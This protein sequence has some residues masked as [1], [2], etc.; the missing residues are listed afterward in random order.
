[1]SIT[2]TNNPYPTEPDASPTKLDR[3]GYEGNAETLDEK[4]NTNFEEVKELITSK[5]IGA[6][7]INGVTP[8]SAI[9]VTGNIYTVV[10]AVGTYVNWNNLVVSANNLAIL[11]R[12]NGVFSISQT[13][14]DITNLKVQNWTAKAYLSGDQVNYLGKDWI[15][16]AATLSTDIPNAS[17]KWSERLGGYKSVLEDINKDYYLNVK[18]TIGKNLYNQA[19][20]TLNN[21][22]HGV[23]GTLIYDTAFQVTDYIKV[24]ANTLY[25][26]TRM[27]FISY[28]DNKLGFIS[29]ASGIVTSF[30]TP[31][32]TAYVRISDSNGVMTAGTQ[33]L[34]VGS[35]K[36]AYEPY[37]VTLPTTKIKDLQIAVSSAIVADGY[38]KPTIGKNI[39]NKA[40][41]TLGFYIDGTTGVLVA[42]ASFQTSDFIKITGSTL[43]QL[44]KNATFFSFFDTNK[45]FISGFST[46]GTNSFTT[47]SNAVYV[48]FSEQN[49]T[50]TSGQMLEAGSVKTTFEEYKYNFDQSY[51][52]SIADSVLT[53]TRIA[54]RFGTVGVDCDYT[55]RRAI[56]DAIDAITDASISKQ[57][58][59]KASGIFEATQSSHFDKGSVG[60]YA[61]IV[62]KPYV[63]LIGSNADDC[64]ITGFLPNNLGVGFQYSS[65]QTMRHDINNS[66][67]E[68]VSL[69]GENL[70]YPLHIDGGRLGCKDF[71]QTI[72]NCKIWHKGNTGDALT[73]WTSTMPFG[74]GTSDGQI[75]TLEDCDIKGKTFASYMHNNQSF[76]LP[77]TIKHLRGSVKTTI[78]YNEQIIRVQSL[79]SGVRDKFIFD[80]CVLDDGCIRYDNSP[81]IPEELI[82]QR[83]DHADTELVM[84]SYDPIVFD[85]SGMTG[86]GLRI[87]SKSTGSGSTVMF[88]QTSTA[89]PLIIGNTNESTEITSRYNNRQIYGYQFRSGGQGL[90]G[91][92]IGTLD[93]GQYLVGIGSNKYIGALGKRLGDCSTINK[94]LTVIIDGNTYNIIFNKNYNGT[95][96]TAVPNYSNTQ[97]IAEIVAVIGIVATVDQYVVGKDYFPQFNNVKNMTNADATEVLSG[98]G[99]VFTSTKNFRKALNSDNKIDGI[100]LDEGRVGDECRIITRGELYSNFANQR[101]CINEVSS[102]TRLIGTQLGISTTVAGKFDVSASP[103][104]VIAKR[105]NVVTFIK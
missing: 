63:H 72:K 43:Y 9:P 28:Y 64:I 20:N 32:N 30:T 10:T 22:A 66:R 89:F 6:D 48:R 11:M 71:I 79:G 17:S 69:I 40:T 100:C 15:S 39:Y 38:V 76:S 82:N 12:I 26:I 34:E 8:T 57:Y 16:N 67:I 2:A 105:D 1:M 74:V 59:I 77:S 78:G 46:A 31:A 50:M 25:Q 98:M 70:R 91:Y 19:T 23:N 52:P 24:S 81:W 80:N 94:T 33:Q 5:L 86:S 83:A 90:S 35:V 37:T 104:L 3:G 61:F 103:K 51:I 56:Q 49:G 21:Y 41:N 45:I 54:K 7:L 27:S 75:I 88:D 55:G 99:V 4:I 73:Q 13:A 102:A 68:N 84:T 47:P 36:T 101:F 96:N 53:I 58:I 97:I 29:K 93:I 18:G 44:A 92:A 60:N 14:L 87:K 65:Y 62:L 85:N 95:A 42:N